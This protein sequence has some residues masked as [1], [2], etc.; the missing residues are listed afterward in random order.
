MK[1]IK[2]SK[3]VLIFI[4]LIFGGLMIYSYFTL[5][6]KVAI[7]FSSG[8]APNDWEGR[9]TY[10]IF[11]GLLGTLS[12]LFVIWIF[13][14]TPNLPKGLIKIPNKED[15]L[16]PDQIQKTKSDLNV[17]GIWLAIILLLIFIFG[18]WVIIDANKQLVVHSIPMYY[19]IVPPLLPI[20]W[21]IWKFIKRFS[22]AS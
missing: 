15:W 11:F 20:V 3:L 1:N 6:D 19:I 5:P 17:Y 22:K 2:A 18:G 8:G 10:V 4:Y 9:L 12:P 13:H 14:I 16:G 21:F 7:H